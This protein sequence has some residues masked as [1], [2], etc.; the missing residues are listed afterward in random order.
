MRR[1]RTRLELG[2]ELSGDEVGVLRLREFDDLD[3]L[4][5]GGCSADLQPRGLKCLP[6]L[7]VVCEFVAVAMSFGDRCRVCV[8]N[9]EAQRRRGNSFVQK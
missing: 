7:A 4:A 1:C 2:V 5:V 8:F 3:E 6:R 9:A